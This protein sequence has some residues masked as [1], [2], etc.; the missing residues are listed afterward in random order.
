V[1]AGGAARLRLR[2]GVPVPD[3]A[4]VMV[5]YV[6][7]THPDVPWFGPGRCPDRALRAEAADGARRRRASWAPARTTSLST[8]CTTPSCRPS[9]ATG[10]TRRRPSSSRL[11]GAH[12]LRT[13]PFAGPA[14]WP[15]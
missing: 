15:R 9:P 14:L 5:L 6:Q 11:L 3:A 4:G 10:C 8:R 13:H 7:H 12:A 1:A 2:A